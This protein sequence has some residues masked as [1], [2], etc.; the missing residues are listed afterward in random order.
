MITTACLP[1]WKIEISGNNKRIGQITNVDVAFYLDKSVEEITSVP[2]GQLL[3]ANG[4]TLIDTIT[5]STVNEDPLTFVWN[6]IAARATLSESGLIS[7]NNEPYKPMDIN[8]TPSSQISDINVSIMDI[9]PTIAHVLGLPGLPDAIGKTRYVSEAEHGVIILLDGLQYQ[10]LLSMRADGRLPFFQEIDVIHQGLTVFPPITT[11]ATAAFLTG[12]PPLIN[13]VFGYGY[14]TTEQ[15]TLFDLAAENGKTVIA[16]EG[17]SLSFNLRNAE[18]TLSGDRDGDGYTDDNV[19]ANSL[20]VIQS[21]MPDMLYIHFHGIDDMGHSY[22][23]DS[24]QYEMA[25][26][27]LDE[28][29]SQIHQELPNRSFIAIFADHGMHRKAGGGNHGTLTALDLI[30]PIVF[31]EK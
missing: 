13:G 12:T 31:L 15:T 11:S 30:I 6:E 17:A 21:G 23:P 19:L 3:Y 5:L 22:G 16:I 2:L 25:L 27:R 26:I 9:A 4:F 1:G 20:D 14:R 10:K 28:Y 8:V 7:I 24:P 29:L 18:T